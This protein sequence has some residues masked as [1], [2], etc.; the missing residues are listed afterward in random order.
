MQRDPRTYLWDARE[1]ANAIADFTRGMSSE[2]FVKNELLVAAVE[3][4]FEI[5]GEA[6]N[7]LAQSAPELAARIPDQRR[8]VAF[9]NIL[10]HG[11]AVVDRG[12]VWHVI[13]ENLPILR[14]TLDDI[15]SER[16]S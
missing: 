12:L 8:I 4:K 2:A 16:R 7:P 5:I 3:R 10:I 1:A 13:Q 14:A 15:L 9:R 11:Y 6:L